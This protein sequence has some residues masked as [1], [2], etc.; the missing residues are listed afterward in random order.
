MVFLL[1]VSLKKN[2]SL[3]FLKDKKC[4]EEKDLLDKTP[5]SRIRQNCD[6]YK[7]FFNGYA[8]SASVIFKAISITKHRV[9]VKL[10]N[11]KAIGL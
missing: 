1:N 5:Q 4:F 8:F 11:K 7:H 9:K 2:L 6:I 10:L 3:N